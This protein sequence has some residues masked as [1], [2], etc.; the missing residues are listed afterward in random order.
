MLKKGWFVED[1]IAKTLENLIT[2][3]EFE[4]FTS[5]E[6]EE[7]EQRLI[8]E[9][10]T[11]AVYPVETQE[12]VERYIREHGADLHEFA[13]KVRSRHLATRREGTA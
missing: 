12:T 5:T 11:I 2:E 8:D 10:R 13:L 7:F 1:S 9:I 4:L 6:R 3:S